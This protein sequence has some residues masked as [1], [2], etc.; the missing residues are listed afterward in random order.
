M[1]TTRAPAPDPPASRWH[2]L[3]P[4]TRL[5]VAVGTVV[6]AILLG[7]VACLAV[8]A[9]LGVVLP[10][11]VA[12]SLREVLRLGL[13]LSLPLAISVVVVNVLLHLLVVREKVRRSGS[14]ENCAPADCPDASGRGDR[15]RSLVT[16][17][18]WRW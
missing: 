6:A 12:G 7:G 2:A 11:L 15:V 3:D 14:G 16:R 18:R 8:L 10:A 1:S 4:L 9:L 17:P 5:V 13:V